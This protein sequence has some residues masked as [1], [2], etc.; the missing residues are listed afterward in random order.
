MNHFGYPETVSDLR[1]LPKGSGASEPIQHLG[2]VC[3]VHDLQPV[4]VWFEFN[5]GAGYWYARRLA[6][7]HNWTRP[8]VYRTRMPHKGHPMLRTASTPHAPAAVT[9][10]PSHSIAQSLERIADALE[11]WLARA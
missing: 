5:D 10:D 1:I 3:P 8:C 4:S 2:G 7:D 9:V 6:K 11:N